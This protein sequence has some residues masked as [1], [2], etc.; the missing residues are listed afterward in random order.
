MFY[1]LGPKVCQA[2]RDFFLC[3][4]LQGSSEGHLI[5]PP[6]THRVTCPRGTACP[7]FPHLKEPALFQAVD[8]FPGDLGPM[9][10]HLPNESTKVVLRAPELGV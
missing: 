4:S 6:P 10:A 2:D 9:G 8:N 3:A 7:S 5:Q 1:A